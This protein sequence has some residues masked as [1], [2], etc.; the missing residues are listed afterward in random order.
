MGLQVAM[1]FNANSGYHYSASDLV[2]TRV[3]NSAPSDLNQVFTEQAG[4]YRTPNFWQSDVRVQYSWKWSQKLQ[5]EVYLDII[6]LT[7]RQ[8][9][10]GLSEGLNIRR[11]ST[12]IYTANI[13]NTPYAFQA[14]RR[15]QVGFRLKY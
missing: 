6:N 11:A 14:P 3:L 7:N 2:G 5:S 1:N 8:E 9:A 4:K 12:E 13:P 15:Y 10:T